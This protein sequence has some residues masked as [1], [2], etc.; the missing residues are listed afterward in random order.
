MKR[1][2]GWRSPGGCP[3]GVRLADAP[4][5]DRGRVVLSRQQTRVLGE[6]RRYID[7]HGYPPTLREISDAFGWSGPS[8]A[9]QAIGWLVRK[10]WLIV[11]KRRS[12]AIRIVAD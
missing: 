11:D 8:A 2:P 6:I 7:D 12:R 4:R 1:A 9:K 3:R 5:D 10:G